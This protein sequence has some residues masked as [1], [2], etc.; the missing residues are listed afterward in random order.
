MNRS[1]FAAAVKIALSKEKYED[2]N[3]R[4]A[5]RDKVIALFSTRE[6]HHYV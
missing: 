2:L 6:I 1:K 5:V 4:D 3:T